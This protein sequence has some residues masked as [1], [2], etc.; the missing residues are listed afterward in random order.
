L[1]ITHIT[2]TQTFCSVRS[3][4]IY[5]TYR[6]QMTGKKKASPNY[7]ITLRGDNVHNKGINRRMNCRP[8]AG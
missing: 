2:E 4:F 6:A 7:N 3:K 8:D 5:Y 1:L